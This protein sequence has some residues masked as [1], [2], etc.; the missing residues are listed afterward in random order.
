MKTVTFKTFLRSLTVEQRKQ[1]KA[2]VLTQIGSGGYKI[3][4]STKESK[5]TFVYRGFVWEDSPEGFEYWNKIAE[6]YE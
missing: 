1:Y 3:L 4:N 2:N 6:S 5:Y